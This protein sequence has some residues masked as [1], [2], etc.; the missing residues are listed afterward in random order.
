MEF[1]KEAGEE[2]ATLYTVRSDTGVNVSL[3]L[4]KRFMDG[5]AKEEKRVG[6][7]MSA[8]VHT[9]TP[10]LEGDSTAGNMELY[11]RDSS[12]AAVAIELDREFSQKSIKKFREKG[13]TPQDFMDSKLDA[14]TAGFSQ[15]LGW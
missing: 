14:A 7:R 5:A 9:I 10:M 11:T 12:I 4:K 15:R 6:A 2:G 1:N 3:K 13:V 8:I